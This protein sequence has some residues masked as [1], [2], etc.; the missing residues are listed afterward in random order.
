ML[1]NVLMFLL[2]LL[3]VMMLGSLF[4]PDRVLIE[5]SIVIAS[6]P[7]K[8]F[9]MLNGFD[10]YAQWS[11]WHKAGMKYQSSGPHSGIGATLEWQSKSRGDGSLEIIS[12][13][14]SQK[15]VTRM[16]FVDHGSVLSRFIFSPGPGGGTRLVWQYDADL[17]EIENPLFHYAGR[18]MALL[19]EKWVAEDFDKGLKK[20][21][22]LSEKNT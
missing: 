11:P 7:A 16:D 14:V 17:S 3:G 1:R 20:I 8:V 12:S 4:L 15:I 19:M 18:Y 22:Q 2:L 9:A 5:R 10:N 21:Q 6:P 13:E